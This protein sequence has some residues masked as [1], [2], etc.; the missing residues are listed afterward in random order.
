M[1]QSSSSEQACFSLKEAL[2]RRSKE[3][4]SS[5]LTGSN[6]GC[7]IKMGT[8]VGV[9]ELELAGMAEL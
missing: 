7:H 3:N 1:T 6:A 2:S 4:L 9:A 5:Q 8:V